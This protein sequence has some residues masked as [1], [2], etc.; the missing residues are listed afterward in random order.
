MHQKDD[1][2]HVMDEIARFELELSWIMH[3]DKAVDLCCTLFE[4]IR[5]FAKEQGIN[6][7]FTTC[8]DELVYTEE[9]LLDM[10][11]VNDVLMIGYPDGL[12]D[13][14]H[15]LPVIRKGITA[16]HPAIDFDGK[17]LGIIDIGCYY[18]SSGSPLFIYP[19][20]YQFSKTKG[21]QIGVT[22]SK[23]LGIFYAFIC[24]NDDGEIIAKVPEKCNRKLH[25]AGVD[26]TSA[27]DDVSLNMGYYIKA[28][29]L[30]GLRNVIFQ[31][32]GLK[33]P[34]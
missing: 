1:G 23:L 21:M 5:Q 2:G 31:K 10:Q 12:Y 18:G 26:T 30:M 27:T 4:P 29:E 14:K 11:T 22:E 16:T 8:T 25:K 28:K 13:E 19:G 33:P 17:S 32:Y 24:A 3:P 9:E 20:V 7:F 6:L 34:Q 15:S